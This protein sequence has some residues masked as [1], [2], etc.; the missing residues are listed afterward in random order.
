M[1]FFLKF[2]RHGSP[3]STKTAGT[4]SMRRLLAVANLSSCWVGAQSR[5]GFD[6]AQ[7]YCPHLCQSLGPKLLK[8]LGFSMYGFPD[9]DTSPYQWRTVLNSL[10]EEPG[11]EAWLCSWLPSLLLTMPRWRTGWLWRRRWPE[12]GS[13]AV[14]QLLPGS[15]FAGLWWKDLERSSES[16]QQK[17]RHA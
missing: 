4:A 10:H 11:D 2:L 9:L 1:L 16:G 5:Q 17:P 7:C 8:F 6:Q 12:S 15:W 14:H 3:V 13:E